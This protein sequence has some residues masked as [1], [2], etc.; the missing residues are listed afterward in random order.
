[1]KRTITEGK[2]FS[3]ILFILLI[4]WIITMIASS[5]DVK[6]SWT[7]IDYLNKGI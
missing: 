4:M 5:Y 6:P 7:A 3:I 1:M 2:R